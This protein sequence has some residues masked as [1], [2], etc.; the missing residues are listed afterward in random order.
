MYVLDKKE[1]NF[2]SIFIFYYLHIDTNCI[3]GQSLS[4]VFSRLP[5][6]KFLDTKKSCYLYIWC[7]VQQSKQVYLFLWYI[8]PYLQGLIFL[9]LS[10]RCFE[11]TVPTQIPL[12][13]N[14]WMK[15]NLNS[16]RF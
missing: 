9:F 2:S 7:R 13:P 12:A 6:L 11:T 10:G 4:Y 5:I 1:S 16:R 14:L 3:K 15:V 8:L